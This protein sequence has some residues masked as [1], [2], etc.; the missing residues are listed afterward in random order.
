MLK[1]DWKAVPLTELEALERD[2]KRY[3]WLRD[4]GQDTVDVFFATENNAS[5]WGCWDSW[6]DKDAAIDAA[7]LKVPNAEVRGCATAETTNGD[8][9]NG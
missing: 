1:E 5:G 4:I 2:A 8:K 6:D 3:R 7:M 9:Q